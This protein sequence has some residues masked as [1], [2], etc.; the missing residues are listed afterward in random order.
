L[1]K[2]L[3][4]QERQQR[5]RL[6]DPGW[7][8]EE[9]EASP[10]PYGHWR[11]QRVRKGYVFPPWLHHCDQPMFLLGKRAAQAATQIEAPQ[12][13]A[14]LALGARVSEH[15]GKKRWRPVLRAAHLKDACPLV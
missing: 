13:L 14:W 9:E 5:R 10:L 1:F 12:R 11:G 2:W 15:P 3:A 6:T 4:P 8:A 7:P